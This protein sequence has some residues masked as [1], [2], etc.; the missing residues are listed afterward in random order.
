ME[1]RDLRRSC[2]L[3]SGTILDPNWKVKRTFG[4]E[5]LFAQIM[6]G[7]HFVTTLLVSLVQ[8]EHT[9]WSIITVTEMKDVKL[10]YTLHAQHAT[11]CMSAA[12]R[13]GDTFSCKCDATQSAGRCV[14]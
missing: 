3:R 1:A 10:K 7:S 4:F 13:N 6:H 8:D 12:P 11:S 5:W 9:A 14:C 2:S